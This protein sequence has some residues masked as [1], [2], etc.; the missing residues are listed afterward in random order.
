MT[1]TVCLAWRPQP[2][3]LAAHRRV[4]DF[5]KS[6]GLPVIES[7]STPGLA[8]HL[9]E[10]RNFAV[11][12]TTGVVIVADADSVADPESIRTAIEL[13]HS[14][15]VVWPFIR[16]H[17]LPPE[18]TDVED[19]S[20]VTPI[21]TKPGRHSSA[22]LSV[23]GMFVTNTETYWRIGGQ[24][25]RLERT[26]GFEDDCFLAAAETLSTVHRV[27]GNL[28]AFAHDVEGGRDWSPK[29]PNYVWAEKYKRARG[30]RARMLALIAR[31]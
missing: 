3:R 23:G 14:D 21:Y 31:D 9:A 18:A 26:W 17:Y 30:N 11:R 12:Q 2:D 10:A 13:A 19:L 29:N 7:D 8:F 15:C 24:D 6:M 28:Y 5:W 27:D 1:V 22:K 4:R 16:Y 20:T 25:D